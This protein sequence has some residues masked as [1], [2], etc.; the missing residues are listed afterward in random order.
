M[1]LLKL[2]QSIEALSKLSVAS[3]LTKALDYATRPQSEFIKY[4]AF[5]IFETLQHTTRDNKDER[6]EYYRLAFQTAR[7]KVV[8]PNE[9]FQ[10]LLLRLLGDNDQ[11]KVFEAV[12]KVEKSMG[13]SPSPRASSSYRSSMA[14]YR[15]RSGRG[16]AGLRCFHCNKLGHVWARCML[17]KAE[18]QMPSSAAGPVSSQQPDK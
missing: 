13:K 11:H 5:D 14:P 9:H 18:A 10:S 17:R 12:A 3:M 16:V 8:L 2:Q 4:E 15:G 6:Q 1:D 7:S